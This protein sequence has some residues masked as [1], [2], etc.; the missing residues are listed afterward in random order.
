MMMKALVFLVMVFCLLL[1]TSPLDKCQ[2]ENPRFIAIKKMDFYIFQILSCLGKTQLCL[3]K[4]FWVVSSGKPNGPH[5]LCLITPEKSGTDFYVSAYEYMY[6]EK[7]E[8]R[9]FENACP[10]KMH[11]DAILNY[12]SLG[13]KIVSSS[14]M[15]EFLH[16]YGVQT[17]PQ[18]FFDQHFHYVFEFSKEHEIK[19]ASLRKGRNK[20]PD[21]VYDLLH[22]EFYR[23]WR[24]E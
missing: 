23:P 4:Q 21:V 14:A 20:L 2:I 6:L 7:N 9:R 3:R 16:Q 22:K 17:D 11:I 5:L 19:K 8:R 15:I 24:V 13:E 10:V 1:Y 12:R 18:T